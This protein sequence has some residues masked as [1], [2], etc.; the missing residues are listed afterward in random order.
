VN[1]EKKRHLYLS[2]YLLQM[3]DENKVSKKATRNVN[4]SSYSPLVETTI[5]HI[6]ERMG[7]NQIIQKRRFLPFV[8]YL[9]VS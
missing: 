9:L 8:L 5:N 1:A 6:L 3:N 2:V 7:N 4:E